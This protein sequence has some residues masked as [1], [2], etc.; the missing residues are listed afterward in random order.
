M[1]GAINLNDAREQ[2]I[3]LKYRQMLLP[4]TSRG[5]PPPTSQERPLKILF[6]HPRNAPN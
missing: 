4:R 1:N 5:R 2:Q 6:D 3:Q